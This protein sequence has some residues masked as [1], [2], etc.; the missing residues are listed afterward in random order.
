[1]KKILIIVLILFCTGCYDYNELNDLE[2]VSSM[3]V[4]YEDG[5]YKIDIEVLDTSESASKGSYYLK[6]KGNTL[7]AAMNDVFFGSASTPFYSHMKTLVVSKAIAERGLDDFFDYLLR[8][9][10]LRKDFY[11]F[12]A[13][14]ID[15]ILKFEPAPRE[16]FGELARMSAKRNQEGNGYYRPGTFRELIYAYLRDNTYM[17]GGLTIDEDIISLTDTYLFTNN[18][19]AFDIDK[20]AALFANMLAGQNKMFQIYGDFTFDIHEYKL[21]KKIEKNKITLSLKGQARLLDART[22]NHLNQDD[23]AKIE[24]DLNTRVEEYAAKTVEYA[25]TMNSDMFNFNHSYYLYYPKLVEDDTWKK[26]EYVFT[27]DLVIGE[28]GLLLDSI[29]GKNGK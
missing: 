11:V 26:I 19:L 25:K 1:M 17:V 27:S 13:E 22:P 5:D 6:G 4:D 28:K 18:T 10:K 9:T 3:I 14:D 2:I 16:S 29:G 12:V 7:E 8:N 21:E 15:K 24:R 20:N 23:L